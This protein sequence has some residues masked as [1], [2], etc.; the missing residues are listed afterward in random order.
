M[1]EK[2]SL[3]IPELTG[4][5]EQA[6]FRDI[7]VYGELKLRPPVPNEGRVFFVARKDT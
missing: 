3:T 6:G 4:F 7:K 5:L 1:I 2:W